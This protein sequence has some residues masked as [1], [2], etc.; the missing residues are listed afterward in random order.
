MPQF[1][2]WGVHAEKLFNESYF[3]SPSTNKRFW[4]FYTPVRQILEVFDHT[5]AGWKQANNNERKLILPDLNN[6]LCLN[7]CCAGV[8]SLATY[9]QNGVR[10]HQNKN[11][12]GQSINAIKGG[13]I[14][15][16]VIHLEKGPDGKSI[17]AVEAANASHS[18]KD[19]LGR[20]LKALKMLEKRD[21]QKNEEGKSAKASAAG[22]LGNVSEWAD[23]NHPEFGITTAAHI[24]RKQKRH[25]YPYGPSN[26]VKSLS[27]TTD[28]SSE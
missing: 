2:Y 1:W 27:P 5:E 22:K 16:M 11:Q 20:S 19:S 8:M 15:G 17:H 24:V 21:S 10:L 7:E 23:P 12:F 13:Q 25:G 14:G 9:K 6:P 26:R 4:E 3:G 18:E 28:N